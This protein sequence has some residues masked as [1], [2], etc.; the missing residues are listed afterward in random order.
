MN[1]YLK[2]K[3]SNCKNCYRCIRHCPVKSIR[4]SDNQANIITEDCILCGRCFLN[5][6]QNAKEIRNDIEKAKSLVQS[7]IPIYAS[8]APSFVANYNDVTIR[9]M[10]KVLKQLGFAGVEETSLGATIVKQQYEDLINNETQDVIISSCCHT[11][12]LLIQKYYPKALPYLAKVVTPMQAHNKDIKRRYMNAKTIFIG[13][14]LSKKAEAESY[15]NGVD[16]VLTFE[17]LSSWLKEENL[18]FEYIEDDFEKGRARLFPTTGGI[19]KTLS[20][21]N[22]DYTYLAIDGIENCMHALEEVINGKISKCFIEM[23]S[24]E[25][26]CIGGPAMDQNHLSPIGDFTRVNSYAKEDDFETFTYEVTDLEAKFSSLVGRSIVFGDASIEEVL[27]QMGKTKPEHELN[28]GSC[29]YNSCR[30]KAKAVLEGKANISMC[31][32]YLK[33]K[34]ESFSDNIISNTP[35]AI[36]VLNEELQVQ[37]INNAACTL[38]NIPSQ[39]D[40]LGDHVVR[41]LDPVPFFE[42]YE[43]GKN[44]YDKREYFAEYQKFVEQTVIY[45]RSY[46]IIICIMKDIT[47]ESRQREQKEVTRQKTIEITN[48]VIE[49]QMR[50]VQEIASLLGETT[51]ETKVALTKLK[52]SLY[53]E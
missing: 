10:E 32:P 23:S 9:S 12:N 2:F 13:P 47:E 11:V 38:L 22:S 52:E 30:D 43:N 6:P 25:G 34:A 16:C 20:A 27:K 42:A 18:I 40:I 35:N 37:Q 19:L 31:L 28:C 46:H 41:I 49:K 15:P 5:C 26:S 3:K 48:N 8:I 17:E 14:C 33:E 39:S 53:D 51:A 24:C 7:G 45:D 29:G 44:T 36:L 4:F 1:D 50:A 21:K